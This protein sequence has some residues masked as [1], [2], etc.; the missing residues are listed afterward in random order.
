MATKAEAKPKEVK[1]YECEVERRRLKQGAHGYETFWKMKSVEDV[2]ADADAKFRCK[3]CAGEVKLFRSSKVGAAAPHAVHKLRADS[4]Y[5]PM[6]IYF[7]QASDGR[8]PRRS[9]RPVE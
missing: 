2:L 7:R 4:E 5:C 3:D 1:L 9:E 8:E 6:G